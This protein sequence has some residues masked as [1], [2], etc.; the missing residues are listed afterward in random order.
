M[1]TDRSAWTRA[2]NLRGWL[3]LVGCLLH[4]VGRAGDAAD[5]RGVPPLNPLLLA[6]EYQALCR[7]P[8]EFIGFSFS[9]T[10]QE[11]EAMKASGAN[12]VGL[13]AMW[14]PVH[15][16]RAPDE[17]G[18]APPINSGRLGQTFV[19][20]AAFDGFAPCLPTSYS[21]DSGCRW[22]LLRSGNGTLKGVASGRFANVKDNAWTEAAFPS[23][24]PG[25]YQFEITEATG[26]WIGW[27]GRQ[28]NPYREGYAVVADRAQ[29]DLDFEFRL[30]TDAKWQEVV[31]PSQTHTALHLGPSPIEVLARMGF[32]ATYAVGDWNNPGFPYYPKWFYD[33]FPDIAALDAE[34]RPVL[35][36]M[37][38]EVVPAPG[39]E[40]PA[41]ADGVSRHIV[42]TATALRDARSLLFWVMGGEEMYATYGNLA[43]WTD[44]SPN[45]LHH[46]R[47]WLLRNRYNSLAALNAAWKS[48]FANADEIVP[49][50]Q[51]SV[52][53]QWLDWLD[54]RFA[55]MA[56]RFAWHYQAL[57]SAD[58]THLAL[59]CN[60]G[61]LYQG[62]NYAAMGG[63]P[64]LYAANSDGFETGQIMTDN[65]PNLYNLMYIETLTTFGKPYCPVRLAYKKSDSHA[66]GGGTSY[67]PEA[68]RRYVYESLGAD[69]W[70]VGLIQWSGSL[71]DGEWGVQG[72]PAEK[73][74]CELF[75]EIRRLRPFLDDMHALRPKVAVFLSHP[76]WALLGF[77]PSWTAFHAAAV[78]HQVAKR[79]VYD[80]QVLNRHVD[81]Y[82]FLV[83]VDNDIV[84][85]NVMAA[86]AAYVRQGGTL[87]VAGGFATRMVD[88]KPN[89]TSLFPRQPGV[90]P[91]GKGRV[92]VVAS[93]DSA[94]ILSALGDETKSVSLKARGSAPKVREIHIARG[95][96]DWPQDLHTHSSLGQT[97]TLPS[98][99]LR[100]VAI[101]TPTYLKK[102]PVG[103]TFQLRRG[104]PAGDVMASRRVPGGI[105]DNC[106]VELDVPPTSA[107][108]GERVYV[109]AIPDPNLPAFHLGWWSTRSD[110]YVEGQAFEDGQ[111]V[112]GDRQVRL[113]FEDN[114]PGEQAVETFVLSDGLNAG[115]VLINTSGIAL[116]LSVDARRTL[117]S[118]VG[119]ITV[120]C[121]LDPT[122]WQGVGTR[123]ALRL[124]P[125][126]TAFLYVRN[127]QA[128][129]AAR[130][131]VTN[132][133]RA[134]KL[135][136]S[137]S[138]ATPLALT[139]AQRG[140]EYL[141]A[142]RPDKAAAAAARVLR[143]LGMAVKG[144]TTLLP[145]GV[146]SFDVRF[147]EAS[148]KP[149]DVE[150]A[151][152]ELVPS[153]NCVVHLSRLS[154]GRYQLR[155][156]VRNLPPRYDYRRRT[157]VP[158]HG[159]LR[160]RLAG[161]LGERK[162]AKAMDVTLLAAPNASLNGGVS[163]V[164]TK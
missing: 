39:I 76:T 132:A 90:H 6:D 45:A 19:A 106:W 87:V 113:I 29:P 121:P 109:E 64:E 154:A 156:P 89:P 25:A 32:H 44:Y 129:R 47:A 56:E 116:D 20:A 27:W 68:A 24:A 118:G 80:G 84:D 123:G 125:H 114:V 142:N 119:E 112:D 16:E 51:P 37:F 153:P 3:A 148:G 33:K 111:P 52:S 160:V 131:L 149:C 85:G 145:D 107:R 54:F 120:S 110:A 55:S 105:G 7:R 65:D 58:T 60:H 43:R 94:A 164:S 40:H 36:G 81:D 134:V 88:D 74:I 150:R 70:D 158:F 31:A 38:D 103:F 86:L 34:G 128:V 4:C 159:P 100:R 72:T 59:T 138:A 2:P 57:R 50:K 140:D 124:E 69:A 73:A 42:A 30:H 22:R 10:K 91:M 21:T 26:S 146:L 98:A 143:Q 141:R 104:G 13:G 82:P 99:G 163:S 8:C 71:P 162:A 62:M 66:R 102:P 79:Y 127:D 151:W 18:I 130:S 1:E 137:Q 41:I 139:M 75:E 157:Y 49:P 97:I 144:D 77:R 14:V 46:F 78:E 61:D 126:G 9:G 155:M 23:Q 93:S 133:A 53:Q 17:C 108:L 115:V 15:D 35:G 135:W 122:R 92:V 117:P 11:L 136:Q 63:R 48:A 12:A 67:T 96:N 101:C 83:S 28:G 152:A 95:G 161:R 147:L 5:A